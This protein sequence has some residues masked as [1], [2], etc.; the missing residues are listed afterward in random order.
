MVLPA[1]AAALKMVGI[2]KYPAEEEYFG[3]G[4]A[5]I[6]NDLYLAIALIKALLTGLISK[7]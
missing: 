5:V 4:V 3:A 2:L 1:L 7:R 6:R